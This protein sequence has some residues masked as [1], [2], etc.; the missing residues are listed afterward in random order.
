MRLALL[1]LLAPVLAAAEPIDATIG[2]A[3]LDAAPPNTVNELKLTLHRSGK[4]VW[5]LLGWKAISGGRPMPASL[6]DVC[7]TVG[8]HVGAQ[9]LGQHTGARFEILCRNGLSGEG[10]FTV[11]GTVVVIDTLEPYKVLWIGEGESI[12]NENDACITR[13]TVEFELKGKSLI[14][15]SIETSR[16]NA[17][18]SCQRG[19]EPGK[20]K[21]KKRSRVVRAVA[22]P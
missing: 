3:I 1:I 22:T 13:R 4:P 10:M 11:N 19:G 17:D 6:S 21:T 2:D 12:S 9:Q 7:E 18:G 5:T 14:E 20:E 16:T 15:N 8:V